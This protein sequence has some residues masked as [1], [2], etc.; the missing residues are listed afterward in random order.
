MEYIKA[1]IQEIISESGKDLNSHTNTVLR[2]ILMGVEVTPS[3]QPKT[4]WIP[5]SER[6]PEK[7]I[8]VLVTTKWDNITIGEMLS[9]NDWLI[10]EGTTYA[11]NDDIKAWMPLP[12]SYKEDE[13]NEM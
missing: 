8:E 7:N 5:C 9:D 6:L 1:H 4:G 11:D 12:Q 3:V 2:A 13:E 10:Y